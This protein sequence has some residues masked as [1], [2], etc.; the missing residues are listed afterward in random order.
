MAPDPC[1]FCGFNHDLSGVIADRLCAGDPISALANDYGMRVY[2][3]SLVALCGM[4][5]LLADAMAGGEG[6]KDAEIARLTRE[7]DAAVA[8]LEAVVERLRSSASVSCRVVGLT[9][10][11]HLA[12]LRAAPQPDDG[13][14]P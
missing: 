13:A 6:A 5:A 1:T 12:R 8:A 2:Q 9:V 4:R 11:A 10:E 14:E 3:T 7:R